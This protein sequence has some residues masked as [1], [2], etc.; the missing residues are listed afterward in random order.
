MGQHP[1]HGPSDGLL[2]L[3]VFS[4]H[5]GFFGHTITVECVLCQ[6]RLSVPI[7]SRILLKPSASFVS[8]GGVKGRKDDKKGFYFL[9]KT[10]R[11]KNSF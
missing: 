7:L 10:C 4:P 3:I 2:L 11:K 8:V 6:F 1:H 5:Q 9:L